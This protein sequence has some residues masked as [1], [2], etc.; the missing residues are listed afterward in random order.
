MSCGWEG[1]HKSGVIDLVFINLRAQDLSKGNV[2]H[3]HQHSS[4]WG[5]VNLLFT[6]YACK[7]KNFNCF[8][9]LCLCGSY[10]DG[11]IE[12]GLCY[13]NNSRICLDQTRAISFIL[14]RS[15][16]ITN[17]LAS[18]YSTDDNR[19]QPTSARGC[20][21]A[22]IRGRPGLNAHQPDGRPAVDASASRVCDILDNG[23]ARVADGR[24]Q[25]AQY[26]VF[27]LLCSVLDILS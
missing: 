15:Y 26:V 11:A 6:F 14:S 7:V 27:V 20:A 3:V 24:I 8:V 25:P 1:N 10:C 5:V 2:H 22:Y 4:S 23:H 12:L 13:R 18:R 19:P 16:Q 9:S 17:R 21:A